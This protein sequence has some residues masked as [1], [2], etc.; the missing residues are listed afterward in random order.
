MSIDEYERV[1]HL[2]KFWEEVGATI[3]NLRN[4]LLDFPVILLLL[5]W[6]LSLRAPH[7]AVLHSL[8]VTVPFGASMQLG[9][10]WLLIAAWS[11]VAAFS[12]V[13]FRRLLRGPVVKRKIRKAMK[14][15]IKIE[16]KRR[17]DELNEWIQLQG[18]AFDL[19][20]GEEV[21]T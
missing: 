8:S 14:H 11:Y 15:R 7:Q 10:V 2:A 16:E 5:F 21:K 4:A 1:V 9:N 17:I 13:P 20:K 19:S 18:F 6:V 3:Q 12:F